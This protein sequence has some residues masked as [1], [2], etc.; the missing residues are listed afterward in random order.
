MDVA[1]DGEGPADQRVG[2]VADAGVVP[3][4]G[5]GRVV[6]LVLASDRG[7]GRFERCYGP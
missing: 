4:K 6:L 7:L 1:E 5:A 3:V 2:L